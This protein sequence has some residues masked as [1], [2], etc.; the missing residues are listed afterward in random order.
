MC[1]TLKN[2]MRILGPATAALALVVPAAANAGTLVLSPL[3]GGE[4]VDGKERLAV[5]QLLGSELGMAPEVDELKRLDAI[6][7]TLDSACLDN[8]RCL[9]R[10]ATANG[11]DRLIAG[12]M[13]QEGTDFEL[14]LVLYEKGVIAR[15]LHAVVP[16]DTTALAT[17]I[18]PVVRELLVGATPTPPPSPVA[19]APSTDADV[20]ALITFGGTAADI[21]A[22]EVDQMIQFAP[23]S[24]VGAAV[25]PAV[26]AAPAAASAPANDIP[27]AMDAPVEVQAEIEPPPRTEATTSGVAANRFQVTARGGY[28]K[29][30]S[31]DFATA[32]G[33]LAVRIY[34]GLLVVGGLEMYA[35]NRQLTEQEQIETGLSKEWNFIYPLN[36][37]LLYELKFGRWEPY[38]GVDM[39][40]VQ[41]YRDEIG[42]DWAGGARFRGGT[43]VML[44]DNFG[45]N[46][47]IAAGFWTG[48]NWIYI[49]E[50]LKESGFLPQI[51]GGAV[52]AF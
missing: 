20:A 30:Y 32:G 26:V 1:E 12:R 43:D 50:G 27:A 51:S 44:V 13:R 28:S 46:V 25:A 5:H 29:Y 34:Q 23:P 37:G 52:V 18:T 40:F 17:A 19:A 7:P 21:S 45:L 2:A 47:N 14:D 6:P 3:L 48:A 22:E 36:T 24:D 39:I 15:H 33:E 16:T 4:G 11:G 31:F 10:M 38:A 42:A 49:E 41:Y 35:V 9:G 8:A